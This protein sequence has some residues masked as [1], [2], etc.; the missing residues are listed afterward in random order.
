MTRFMFSSSSPHRRPSA[1]PGFP[2]AASGVAGPHPGLPGYSSCPAGSNWNFYSWRG[3][4]ERF[5]HSFLFPHALAFY[6]GILGLADD[7]DRLAA[8]AGYVLAYKLTESRIETSPAVFGTCGD[9]TSA[10]PPRC[11]NNLNLSDGCCAHPPRGQPIRGARLDRLKQM[12]VCGS[13]GL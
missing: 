5:I 7:H 4:V 1:T 6:A 11:S 10:K 9:W 12:P 2:R 13:S 3:R 8:V